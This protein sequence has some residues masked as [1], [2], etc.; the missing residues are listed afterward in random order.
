MQNTPHIPVMLNEV[1]ENLN[2]KDKGVYIDGTFGNGGYTS[3]ILDA[4]DTTVIAFEDLADG[5]ICYQ[6]NT[7]QSKVNW[8]QNIGT[9]P[10]P[11]PAAFGSGQVYASGVTSCKGTSAEALTY[12]NTRSNVVNTAHK[13]DKYGI[14]TTCGCFN[15]H[16][17][18]FDDVTKFDPTD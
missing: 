8:V 18:E 17:F 11:V 10:F 7:D 13:F 14:C 6:L 16:A 4:K 12:T 2:I 15:F 9:D 1:L 5:K 3:A